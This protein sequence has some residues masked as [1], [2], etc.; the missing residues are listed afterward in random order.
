MNS[1]NNHA[2]SDL[3]INFALAAWNPVQLYYWIKCMV[4][5]ACNCSTCRVGHGNGLRL[6]FLLSPDPSSEKLTKKNNQEGLNNSNAS[7]SC[8]VTHAV[9]EDLKKN[10]KKNKYIQ[11]WYLM[12]AGQLHIKPDF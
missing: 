5:H 9:T 11:L 7:W 2:S 12:H 4:A 8:L 10:K 6:G 1:D 3:R